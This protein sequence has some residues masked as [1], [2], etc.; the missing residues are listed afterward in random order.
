[1]EILVYGLVCLV[2]FA[3]ASLAGCPPVAV[4]DIKD[5]IA[6]TVP[7][8]CSVV[9]QDCPP[10]LTCCPGVC[11]STTCM[12]IRAK[13]ITRRCEP[14]P[15]VKCPF[16]YEKDADGCPTCTCNNCPPVKCSVRCPHGYIKD[17][18][19]CINCR[20][21]VVHPN[22]CPSVPFH[23]PSDCAAVLVINECSFEKQD[24]PDGQTCCPGICGSRT[25]QFVGSAP[26]GQCPVLP[27]FPPHDCASRSVISECS[28]DKQNCPN[29]KTCCPGVC[30]SMTCLILGY[31]CP[32]LRCP[33]PPGGLC[34]FG[35]L[36]D[37]NG[38][39]TCTCNGLFPYDWSVAATVKRAC[40]CGP[41]CCRL[42]CRHGYVR[43]ANGCERCKCKLGF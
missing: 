36:K 26:I 37:V 11:G 33:A 30:G 25:C 1:M 20:C 6:R 31:V 28:V 5:C 40:P 13:C 41:K 15:G 23:R 4:Y 22:Q 39:Q 9:E 2:S 24:C 8:L 32:V 12:K 14:R 38:C 43:D 10:G 17:S 19:G 34:P 35:Y 7:N 3:G 21:K 42:F 29:G 18:N 16:G 27:L